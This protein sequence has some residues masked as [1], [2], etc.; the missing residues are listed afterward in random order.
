MAV[1]Y[2]IL[3]IVV[4]FEIAAWTVLLAAVLEGANLSPFFRNAGALFVGILW[5][6]GIYAFDKGLLTMDLST[7]GFSKW[8]GFLGRVTLVLLSAV[9]TAQP[10]EQLV[11]RGEIEERL[12]QEIVLEE[13]IAHLEPYKKYEQEAMSQLIAVNDV[14]PDKLLTN[15][16]AQADE[17]KKKA[18][19]ALAQARSA[20]QERQG[21]VEQTRAR[22]AVLR[23][24]NN[25]LR[26]DPLSVDEAR[27]V[28]VELAA[29]DARLAQAEA[30]LARLSKEEGRAA[31]EQSAAAQAQ[32]DALKAIQTGKG[33]T[34]AGKQQLAEERRQQAEAF[35]RFVRNIQRSRYGDPLKTPSGEDLKWKPASFIARKLILDDLLRQTPPRWP[36]AELKRREE[37]ASLFGLQAADGNVATGKDYFWQWLGVMILA[38]LIPMLSIFYKL[39]SSAEMRAYYSA[40]S[41][42]RAGNPDAIRHLRVRSKEPLADSP[43]PSDFV[44]S[45]A[46]VKED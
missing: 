18:D 24:R 45:T 23:A 1:A 9:L 40:K 5:G 27:R 33:I 14:Q 35:Q 22:Q 37:A 43:S 7:P 4:T 25:A 21:A 19:A 31:G 3:G 15:R 29:V 13:A 8:G 38:A 41:Q 28:A 11:F 26:S 17:E 44:S 39:V 42:A 30:D 32:Q 10:I 46:T 36:P 20:A 12:K 34:I 2:W 16:L 6:G